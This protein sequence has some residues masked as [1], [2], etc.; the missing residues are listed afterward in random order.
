VIQRADVLKLPVA[1]PLEAGGLLVDGEIAFEAYGHPSPDKAL[2]LL[3]DFTQSH[4]ALD[5]WGKSLVGKGNPI[6]PSQYWVVSTNLLGSAFGSTSAAML[7]GEAGDPYEFTIEDMARAAA[8]AM[9]VLEVKRP[10]VVCG[11]GLGGMVA[12]KMAALFPELVGGVMTFGVSISLPSTL[13]ELLSAT[14]HAVGAGTLRRARLEWLRREHDRHALT[15]RFGDNAAVEAWLAQQAES[16]TE[17]F[18][19]RC[20][21]ALAGAYAQADLRE[22]LEKV[23]CRALVVAGAPDEVAPATQVREVYHRVQ[24]SGGKASFY[25]VPSP[26]GHAEL[27]ADV[28]RI[29]GAI[30]EFLTSLD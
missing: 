3:H 13:R 6:D 27:L 22:V 2:L 23:T 26:G 7:Q 14:W 20:Y 25:E 15:A 17:S 28:G 8:S 9:R 11:V 5:S 10:R 18:D 4:R 19:P 29:K 16:F 1:L 24:A 12:F 30:R 21:A